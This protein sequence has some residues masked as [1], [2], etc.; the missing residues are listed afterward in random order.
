MPVLELACFLDA[1]IMRDVFWAG[2]PVPA[3]SGH[4]VTACPVLD[5]RPT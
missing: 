3:D 5:G 4:L 1:V 2:S